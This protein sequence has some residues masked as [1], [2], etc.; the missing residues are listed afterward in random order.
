MNR[1]WK[2]IVLIAMGVAAT[3]CG[4]PATE[5]TTAEPEPV[6]VATEPDPTAVD[7]DHYKVEFEND[8]V[9]I[10][11]ITYGP[12]ETSVMHYHP[13]SL[14]VFLTDQH[15]N[16][17]Q[18]DGTANVIEAKAGEQRFAAGGPHLSKNLADEPSELILVELKGS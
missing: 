4:Q 3:S 10:L 9:R 12:G 11:R 15:V 17:E 14:A 16:L 6:A 13:E 1:M 8:Q 5:T 2:T 7:A 18:P